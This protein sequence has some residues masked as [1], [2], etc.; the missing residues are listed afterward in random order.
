MTI[1]CGLHAASAATSRPRT[2]A[3]AEYLAA[4]RECRDPGPRLARLTAELDRPLGADAFG[5]LVIDGWDARTPAERQAFGALAEEKVLRGL[6][7][8]YER[9]LCTAGARVMGATFDESAHLE[10]LSVEYR[11]AGERMHVFLTFAPDGDHWS[12]AGSWRPDSSPLPG[13]DP[14]D[15]ARYWRPRLGDGRYAEALKALASMP[16]FAMPRGALDELLT[17]P[18]DR[19]PSGRWARPAGNADPFAVVGPPELPYLN[20]V[21]LGALDEPVEVLRD[22]GAGRPLRVF[23]RGQVMRLVVS[24]PAER[25]AEVTT[26]RATV[27]PDAE[28]HAAS[29]QLAPGL[30]VSRLDG[31]GDRVRI[32]YLDDELEL[33]GLVDQELVGRSYTGDRLFDAVPAPSGALPD[34][35]ELLSEPG[36]APFA[37]LPKGGGVQVVGRPQR[38]HVLVRWRGSTGRTIVTGWIARERLE[39][40]HDEPGHFLG[41]DGMHGTWT[42]VAG[43]PGNGLTRVRVKQGTPL[44]ESPDGAMTGLVTKDIDL[45]L[46]GQS[47]R[48][49]EV[50]VGHPFGLAHLWI[51]EAARIEAAPTSD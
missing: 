41:A 16:S 26:R 7:E 46:L 9:Q 17:R 39:R 19:A 25:F 12:Y 10:R 24:V 51:D 6:R 30:P 4:R 3:Q 11:F 14:H 45:I 2:T 28:G 5:K 29:A 8:D 49:L 35:S 37:Y 42:T 40:V 20:R 23:L 1:A 48:W 44:R 38:G 47:G 50:G 21:A 13:Q 43:L 15:L 32:A 27:T 36:G 34:A 31:A 33:T 22:E 18:P